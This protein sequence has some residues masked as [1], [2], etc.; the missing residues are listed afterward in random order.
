MMV[1]TA[2]VI[3]KAWLATL[4]MV[5]LQGTLLA[6]LAIVVTRAIGRSRPAWQAG[7]WLVV[8]AKFALPWGPAMPYSLA[9]LFALLS[10]HH[11]AAVASGPPAL[12]PL[13]APPHA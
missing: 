3:A 4:G 2:G 13:P 8:V 12:Q 11:A 9:D 1:V 10:P 6:L 5:A 7:V